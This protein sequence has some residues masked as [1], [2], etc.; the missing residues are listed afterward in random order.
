MPIK[1]LNFRDK[2]K[3]RIKIIINNK[4]IEQVNH[5]KYLGGDLTYNYTKNIENK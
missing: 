5:F 1:I 3:G 2:E 4:L